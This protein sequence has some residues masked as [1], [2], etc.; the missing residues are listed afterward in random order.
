MKLRT[1]GSCAAALVMA[2]VCAAQGFGGPPQGG[3]PQGG[4][5]G[6]GQ[7]PGGPGGRMGGPMN[8]VMLLSRKDVQDD[9]QLTADQKSK[10]NQLRQNF[11]PGPRPDDDGDPDQM[12]Q[13]ME[14]RQADEKK[15]VDAIL[16]DTQKK[17][18]G[19]IKIQIQGGMALLDPEVQAALGVSDDQKDKLRDVMEEQRENMRPPDPGEGGERPD[20]QQMMA[21]M[22][23]AQEKL[24][25][26]LVAVLTSDQQA[27]FKTMAG[28]TFKQQNQGFGPGGP[29]GGPGGR[30]RGDGGFGGPPPA[31]F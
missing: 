17:R 6:F 22:K 9:L 18:L 24:T 7:G 29:G 8:G 16:T 21:Q 1:I 23:K 20:P 4:P 19:E 2:T 26:A 30:G 25:A 13:A 28:K 14:K 27:K 11:R 31:G 10:L 5:G 12:R 3:P 15:Q